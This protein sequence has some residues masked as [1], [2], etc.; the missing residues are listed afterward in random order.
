MAEYVELILNFCPIHSPCYLEN[1]L[2]KGTFLPLFSLSILLDVSIFF[3]PSFNPLVVVDQDTWRQEVAF[4][5][6]CL[7]ASPE[8]SL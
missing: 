7:A 2:K 4:P 5:S 8:R 3:Q 6:R 1:T